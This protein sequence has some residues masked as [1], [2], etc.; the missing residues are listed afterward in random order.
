MFDFRA[1]KKHTYFNAKF[2]L[3]NL[4]N[5]NIMSKFFTF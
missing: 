1:I 3:Q 4:E 5:A 2:E